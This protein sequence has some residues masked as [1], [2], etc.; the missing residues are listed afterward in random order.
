MIFLYASQGHPL[1]PEGQLIYQLHNLIWIKPLQALREKGDPIA[2]ICCDD[3]RYMKSLA[4]TNFAIYM[5]FL[6]SIIVCIPLKYPGWLTWVLFIPEWI[7]TGAGAWLGPHAILF[8]FHL[9]PYTVISVGL[10]YV[11]IMPGCTIMRPGIREKLLTLKLPPGEILKSLTRITNL[12]II[13]YLLFFMLIA[14]ILRV[15]LITLQL[16]DF[17]VLI[18]EYGMN[19]Y[20]GIAVDITCLILMIHGKIFSSYYCSMVFPQ[21]W[22]AFLLSIW[23]TI[24]YWILFA[25][26]Y[27]INTEFLYPLIFKAELELN[28]I[29]LNWVLYANWIMTGCV[30]T[31]YAYFLMAR[32]SIYKRWNL[33]QA[34]ATA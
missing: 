31:L 3:A 22:K 26:L 15:V 11:S 10:G 18:A 17:D 16:G 25:I 14:A 34:V 29:S 4:W 7:Q 28:T 19:P 1:R 27:F 12:L 5:G 21:V 24:E 6:V 9:V 2:S 33:T 8:G 23:M 32:S 13:R 20:F 30:G